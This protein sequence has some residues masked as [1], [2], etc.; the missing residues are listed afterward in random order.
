MSRPVAPL[1]GVVRAATTFLILALAI[2]SFRGPLSVLAEPYGSG[3]GI[4]IAGGGSGG[5][6][7]FG[8]GYLSESAG[9]AITTRCPRIC[10]CNGQTVDCSHRG[11]TQVPK[12][13]PAETERL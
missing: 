6:S 10:T 9:T 4:H 3:V 13:I 1:N 11:L 7:S 12:R 2:V 8:G 5:I